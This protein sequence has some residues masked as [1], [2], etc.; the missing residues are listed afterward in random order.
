MEAKLRYPRVS[1]PRINAC[2]SAGSQ[3]SLRRRDASL[4]LSR[5]KEVESDDGAG[6]GA[7]DSEEED[8]DEVADSGR[9]TLC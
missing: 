5:E 4:V 9:S 8:E 2:S 1:N 6:T 3:I 7:G